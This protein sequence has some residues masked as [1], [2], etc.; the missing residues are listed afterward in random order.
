MYTAALMLSDVLCDFNVVLLKT[1]ASDLTHR[2]G[3]RPSLGQD[4]TTTVCVMDLVTFS[5][6]LDVLPLSCDMSTFK[7]SEEVLTVFSNC[8]VQLQKNCFLFLVLTL[9]S[10]RAV[11][12]NC[13]KLANENRDTSQKELERY[14]K[15]LWIQI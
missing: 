10:C 5:L 9:H 11:L 15:H 6:M 13:S 2:Q 14:H 8:D 7:E 12:V 3:E 1:S 4:Q